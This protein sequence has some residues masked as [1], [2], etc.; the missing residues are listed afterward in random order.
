LPDPDGKNERELILDQLKKKKVTKVYAQLDPNGRSYH[1]IED[2]K[3]SK[4]VVTKKNGS[5]E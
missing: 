3:Y 1:I 2:D 5:H 4:P